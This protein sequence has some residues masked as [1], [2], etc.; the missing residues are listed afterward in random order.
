MVVPN[1]FTKIRKALLLEWV[2]IGEDCTWDSHPQGMGEY[3]LH[4]Y[5]EIGLSI[6]TSQTILFIFGS[7]WNVHPSTIVL[8]HSQMWYFPRF[9]RSCPQKMQAVWLQCRTGLVVVDGG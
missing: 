4:N 2:T 7:F 6:L 1:L 8:T 5:T 9:G 3:Q